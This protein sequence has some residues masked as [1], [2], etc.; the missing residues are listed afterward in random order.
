MKLRKKT[1]PT[2]KP[3]AEAKE[4]IN[5]ILAVGTPLETENVR[6]AA[7]NK[8]TETSNNYRTR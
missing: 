7:I 2:I 4:L 8:P 1:L 6:I 3:Y 5:E